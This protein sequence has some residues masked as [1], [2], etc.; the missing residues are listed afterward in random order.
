MPK[1]YDPFSK[2]PEITKG[3]NYPN[4]KVEE[5][6]TNEV[7]ENIS[8]LMSA[9]ISQIGLEKFNSLNFDVCS[10]FQ[11]FSLGKNGDIL[12]G[13]K[14]LKSKDN[15]S[16]I[17]SEVNNLLTQAIEEQKERKKIVNKEEQIGEL[18]RNWYAEHHG[19]PWR[20]RFSLNIMDLNDLANF[21]NNKQKLENVLKELCSKYGVEMD[22]IS[23]GISDSGGTRSA[24]KYGTEAFIA[25]ATPV[26]MYCF[27]CSV[28][29][30]M[31]GLATGTLDAVGYS[32]KGESTVHN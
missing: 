26:L 31:G 10:I 24:N 1:E 21:E 12:I 13:Y 22:V 28:F 30:G 15:I 9:I 7:R 4:V 8:I 23:I 2:E 16:Y 11:P 20:F 18:N 5:G 3:K 14:Y 25:F 17:V 27:L 6:I 32:L 29:T 19:N